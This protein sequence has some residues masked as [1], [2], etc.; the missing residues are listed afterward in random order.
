MPFDGLTL[1]RIAQELREELLGARLERIHQPSELE[2]WLLF[3]RQGKKSELWISAQA[4]A[5]RVHLTQL[6]QR[7]PSR[8]TP[9]LLLLRRHLEGGRLSAVEQPDLERILFLDLAGT[10]ELRRPVSY[11]LAIEIM[12]KHSNIILLDPREGKIL[13]GIKRYS[14]ALSR[15][16]EVLPGR[17]YLIPPSNKLDP[18]SLSEEAF[19]SSLLSSFTPETTLARAAQQRFNGLSSTTVVHILRQA[20]LPE[21]ITLAQCG[22]YE[23]NQLRFALEQVLEEVTQGR[24]Q[25]TLLLEGETLVDFFPFSPVGD[26]SRQIGTM[27]ELVDR[28]YALRLRGQQMEAQR[29]EL[30]RKIS[31]RIEQ[32]EKRLATLETL[33]ATT[34][35]EQYRLW[36]E[37]LLA[38]LYRVAPGQEKVE[39]E[40]YHHPE[41]APVVIPLDPYLSPS[42]CAQ[43]YFNL[44]RRAQKTRDRAL[45]EKTALTAELTYLASLATSLQQAREP[46]TIASIAAALEGNKDLPTL[47]PQEP[48]VRPLQLRS[49]SGFIVWVGKNQRQNEQVTFQLAAPDDWWFHAR[50]IPGAHVVLKTGKQEPAPADLHCAATLAAYFSQARESSRVE[51]D[52]T[53]RSFVRRADK[54]RPGLV[55]YTQE[56]TLAVDPREAER[57]L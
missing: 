56:Q 22:L 9:F 20:N 3:R 47:L 36:G 19:F 23:L 34:D 7:P 38:N 24:S 30:Q 31:R 49:P 25:P 39:L 41:A 54:K 1:N 4:H 46:E 2:L 29:R 8:A 53:R 26:W 13:D 50:G 42:E 5:A 44:Y 45:E 37:L 28:Y 43:R 27:N 11:R 21:S 33:L 14:H 52:Y 40:N 57:Y 48:E 15:Y 17:P 10:D 18:R 6:P 12:G 32:A 51:V 35:P 55:F 16:R